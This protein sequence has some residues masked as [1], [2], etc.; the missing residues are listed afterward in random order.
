[1][2]NADLPFA[3]H[4]DIPDYRLMGMQLFNMMHSYWKDD[5]MDRFYRS[6]RKTSMTRVCSR[7]AVSAPHRP[8]G[9][10]LS[11]PKTAS[12]RVLRFLPHSPPDFN[13]HRRFYCLC[14]AS[15]KGQPDTKVRDERHSRAR[16]AT[17]RR[18]NSSPSF[19][20]WT[21]GAGGPSPH[22]GS[23]KKHHR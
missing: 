13:V 17:T 2:R 12:G 8:S 7:P 6:E 4:L 18:P 11:F 19:E 23:T 15:F 1:M 16:A 10:F 14:P 21:G 3:P 22:G 9:T 20:A 5:A